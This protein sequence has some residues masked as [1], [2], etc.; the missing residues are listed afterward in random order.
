M[1]GKNIDVNEYVHSIKYVDFDKII[2]KSF[3]EFKKI[4]NILDP[5]AELFYRNKIAKYIGDTLLI[6][7]HTKNFL[8]N[9]DKCLLIEN[10]EKY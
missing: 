6:S 3:K 5:Q 9:F 8:E 1:D 2:D 10:S 4:F 7:S